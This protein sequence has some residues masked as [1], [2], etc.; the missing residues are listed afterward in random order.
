ML[1]KAIMNLRNHK[2]LEARKE[3]GLTQAQ[4]GKACDV[5]ATTISEIECL[6]LE[7]IN[8]AKEAVRKVSNFLGIDI[9]DVAPAGLCGV[10]FST[11]FES[12]QEVDTQA[13]LL[14]GVSRQEQQTLPSPS[15][16]MEHEELTEHFMGILKENMHCLSKNQQ[17]IIGLRYGLT[18]E[19]ALTYKEIGKRKKRTVEAIRQSEA[20]AIRK[21]RHVIEVKTRLSDTKTYY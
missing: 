12:V 10:K 3:L 8:P 19:G 16:I 17:D 9:E 18:D 6:R 1:I 11:K 20:M 4:L 13:L 21:L 2:V 5:P 7:R 15:D 14:Y